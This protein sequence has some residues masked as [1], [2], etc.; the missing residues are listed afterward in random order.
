MRGTPDCKQVCTAQ[1][2]E[3]DASMLEAPMLSE[4]GRSSD[5]GDL[6]DSVVHKGFTDA[7]RF[8][9]LAAGSTHLE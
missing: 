2:A 1:V 4:A 8:G 5:P 9:T 3:D 7:R 6:L